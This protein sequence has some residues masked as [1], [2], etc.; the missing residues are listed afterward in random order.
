M[1]LEKSDLILCFSSMCVVE[2]KNEDAT[3]KQFFNF[4][5]SYEGLF[6]Q[7]CLII[8]NEFFWS[9]FLNT[10]KYSHFFSIAVASEMSQMLD[11]YF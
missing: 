7:A 1:K 8:W 5:L 6:S 10:R 11:F 2:W 9:D 4:S 3:L